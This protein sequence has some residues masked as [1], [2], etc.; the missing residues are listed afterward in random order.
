MADINTGFEIEVSAVVDEAS[1]KEAGKKLNTYVLNSLKDGYIKIPAAVEAEFNKDGKASKELREAHREFIKQWK[2]MSSV[3]FDSSSEELDDFIKKYDKFTKLMS[4]EGQYNTKQNNALKKSGLG[5][6]LRTYTNQVNA[7][8]K[9]MAQL[10]KI[11]TTSHR[12]TRSDRKSKLSKEELDRYMK[13]KESYHPIPGKARTNV[14]A[15]EHVTETTLKETKYQG[16]YRSGFSR[17]NAVSMKEERPNELKSLKTKIVGVKKANEYAEKVLNEGKLYDSDVIRSRNKTSFS[18]TEKSSK[19]SK[20]ALKEA[21]RVLSDIERSK[22]GE[23]GVEEHRAL[24]QGSFALNQ[25]SGKPVLDTTLDAVNSV[26]ERYFK[27]VGNIELG[28]D[29]YAKGEGPGHELAEQVIKNTLDIVKK[30]LA[31]VNG[32][33]EDAEFQRQ[34]RELAKID[35]E[36][37]IKQMSGLV[38]LS[39]DQNTILKQV[40]SRLKLNGNTTSSKESTSMNSVKTVAEKILTQNKVEAISER[41]ADDK[42]VKASRRLIDTA[43]SDANTGFN[44]DANAT[45]LISTQEKNSK[46]LGKD[47]LTGITRNIS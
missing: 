12:Q 41:V 23:E 18:E 46:I 35:P 16:S 36:A 7:I 37:A 32:I 30:E 27:D 13:P 28:G 40:L 6:L 33:G 2:K 25:M 20:V 29:E 3:G 42:E 10:K 47:I 15:P 43:A 17:M 11:D 24:V 31:G 45:K 26:I 1:A 5:S 44:S 22:K 21:A 8:E 34:M 14:K 39:E 38:T 4:K 9:Q 19:V